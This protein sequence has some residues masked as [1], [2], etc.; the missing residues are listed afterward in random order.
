MS[1]FKHSF[2]PVIIII[3]IIII[4]LETG[5]S[6]IGRWIKKNTSTDLRGTFTVLGKLRSC[7]D[8]LMATRGSRGRQDSDTRCYCEYEDR[9]AS[10]ATHS[11]DCSKTSCASRQ[12]SCWNCNISR[13]CMLLHVSLHCAGISCWSPWSQLSAWTDS[14]SNDKH[15][16]TDGV[17]RWLTILLC[18]YSAN[19]HRHWL[20]AC[21][22]G[23]PRPPSH[24]DVTFSSLARPYHGRLCTS[25]TRWLS[26][27]LTCSSE[28]LIIGSQLIKKMEITY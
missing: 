24:G 25:S 19:S 15:H 21:H 16:I 12:R 7:K 8:V 10:S 20:V 13:Y 2:Y 5:E 28:A 26:P 22:Y 18:C 11:S 23:R 1:V 14:P 27:V 3:F 17:T 6:L 9:Q 4:S